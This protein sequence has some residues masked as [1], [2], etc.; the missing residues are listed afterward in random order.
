MPTFPRPALL[1]VCMVLGAAACERN[2][3]SDKQAAASSVCDSAA[4]VRV[5]TDSLA[6]RYSFRSSVIR[7]TSDSTGSH[8]VT[9]PDPTLTPRVLDGM[10][11]I[12]VSSACR[13]TSLALKDSA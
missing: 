2:D 8:I 1:L 6:K 3:R 12:R 7:F 11:E 13:I 4:A 10:A 5:A 9:W